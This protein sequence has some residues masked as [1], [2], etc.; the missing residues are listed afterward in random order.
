MKRDDIKPP[1]Y[2]WLMDIITAIIFVA[3]VLLITYGISTL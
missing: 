3:L 2:A 1:P